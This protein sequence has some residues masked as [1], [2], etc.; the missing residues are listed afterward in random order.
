MRKFLLATASTVTFFGLGI[1]ALA[2]V[3]VAQQ[4]NCND[5]QTQSEMNACA[6]ISYQN[7]DR[8]LNQVYQQLLPK[9][10]AARKQKLVTAQQA[11]LR[12][13]DAS[14]VFERSEVE[15]GTMAP[16]I[17]SGCLATVTEQ[18]TKDLE[19]YLDS[20]NNR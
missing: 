12:F 6:G 1:A 10:P 4:P 8:K 14:C 5:P 3:R 9:L 18:R 11:W 17:Y 7:A 19:R 20:V 16:M 15:G 2:D 13:R